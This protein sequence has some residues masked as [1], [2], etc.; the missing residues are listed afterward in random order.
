[1]ADEKRRYQT[2]NGMD[3]PANFRGVPILPFVG[4]LVG[5]LIT[6]GLTLAITGPWGGL[7]G[8]NFC[9]PLGHKT[10]VVD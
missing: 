7:C 1:M 8:Q 4:L 3:R 2:W 10:V 9:A 5:G 6:T